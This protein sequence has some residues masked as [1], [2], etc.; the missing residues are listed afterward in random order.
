MI[1]SSNVIA[2]LKDQ[3]EKPDLHYHGAMVLVRRIEELEAKLKAS[4][5]GSGES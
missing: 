4:V 3:T 2:W 5:K 1:D